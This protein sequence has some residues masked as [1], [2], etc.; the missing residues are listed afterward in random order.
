[1]PTVVWVVVTFVVLGELTLLSVNDRTPVTF[2]AV[3][4]APTAQDRRN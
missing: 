4:G 1:M 2:V 3:W